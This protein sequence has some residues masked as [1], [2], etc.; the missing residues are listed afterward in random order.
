VD[1]AS[2]ATTLAWAGVSNGVDY[3]FRVSAANA[4]GTGPW[5]E[6]SVTLTPF[7]VPAAPSSV[8]ASGGDASA[9]L[10]WSAPAFDGGS[11]VTGYR[12]EYSTDAGANWTVVIDDTASVDTSLV[13]DGLTNGVGYLFRVAAINAAGVGDTAIA[14]AQVNPRTTA[15]APV[16]TAAVAG[17]GTVALSW[18]PPL[19]DGGSAVTG[20]VV[21]YRPE[22]SGEWT[23]AGAAIDTTT[24]V[25]DGLVNGE[26]Y[27]F[28]VRAVTSVGDGDW[29]A[30]VSA[31]PV[32]VPSPPPGVAVA[33]SDAAVTVSWSTPASDG[34]SPIIDYV[35]EASVDAGA[36]WVAVTDGASTANSTVAADL[37]NG[38][39]H[40]FR[41][42]AVN[43]VG[44][45]GW[46]PTSSAA[47]PA[48]A[49]PAPVAVT[50]GYP[51]DV[52]AGILRSLADGETP[53]AFQTRAIIVAAGLTGR[54]RD[55]D[56]LPLPPPAPFTADEHVVTT[57]YAGGTDADILTAFA[58]SVGYP[59]TETQ[60]AATYL[61]VFITDLTAWSDSQ[62]GNW[63]D[64]L[65][66]S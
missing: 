19:I 11:P 43:E 34:G 65:T 56:T 2:A 42:R 33:A 16:S 17:N 10:G 38:T 64:Y 57:V 32:T 21:A 54:A 51:D 60:Y 6:A 28:R 61:L 62:L 52:W 45:S 46:S 13:V 26:G 9:V 23:V 40:V 30:T 5:S 36:T 49:A 48:A 44:A 55:A 25:I 29:S 58:D 4:A 35:V 18:L 31:T 20:Y 47:T 39:A 50:V 1:G 15:S 8:V 12:V 27:V 3:A 24:T 53:E 14:S 22:T 63:L 7:G 41:V 66:T 59:I 37:A